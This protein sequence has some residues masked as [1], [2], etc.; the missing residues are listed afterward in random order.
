MLYI[1]TPKQLLPERF[2]FFRARIRRH[3]QEIREQRLDELPFSTRRERASLLDFL[4]DAIDQN[5]VIERYMEW[6]R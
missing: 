2:I 6:A 3:L 4:S 1:S 5:D